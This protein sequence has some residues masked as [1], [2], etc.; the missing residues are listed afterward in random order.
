MQKFKVLLIYPNLQMSTLLPISIPVLSAC[1]KKEGFE[2]ELFDTTNY[3]TASLSFDKQKEELLQVKPFDDAGEYKGSERDMIADLMNVVKD[4][5]PDLIGISLVEDTIE[6]GLLLLDAIKHYEKGFVPRIA[7]GIGVNWNRKKLFQSGLID[8]LCIGEGEKTL[9]D[10]CRKVKNKE[11]LIYVDGLDYPLSS[12]PLIMRKPVDVNELPFIDL[13]IFPRD[14]MVRTM[15][16]K[17]FSMLHVEVDRGCPFSCTYCCSP[18]LNKMYDRK[19][20]RRK[21]PLRLIKELEYLKKK[22]NPDYV[23]LNAET[24]LARPF[25]ELSFTLSNYKRH[26][27]IPFWCQARTENVTENKLKLLKDFG[28]ADMQFGIEHGNEEFRKKH[29][30]RKGSNN[31]MLKSFE[32]VEQYNIPYTVNNIIGFPDDTRETVF[33]TIELNRQINPKNQ[34]V[35]MLTPY[36]G[37]KIYDYCVKEGLLDPEAQPKTLLG[38]KDINYRYM[39]RAELEGLQRTFPMYAKFE[40][41]M[42]SEIEKAEKF[43]AHGNRMFQSLSDVYRE[44]F[45]K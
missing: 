4:Y 12:R 17:N 11:G 31:Q 9:V 25:G 28:V 36:K 22:H 44:R 38:G 26:I 20:Y 13:D 33:D 35:Y 14:R 1:L 7:G 18:A 45:Y 34:N 37:T 27:D 10:A 8:A 5:Q 29:L 21:D 6:Q 40:R 19:Y 16:G 43:T 15:H 3:K 24:L 42:F 2:V 32:L 41:L 30:N 39:T 23:E